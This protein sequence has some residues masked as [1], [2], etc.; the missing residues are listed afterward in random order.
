[1]QS[2]STGRASS[3]KTID[4]GDTESTALLWIKAAI[5][6]PLWAVPLVPFVGYFCRALG[7]LPNQLGLGVVLVLALI[8]FFEGVLRQKIRMDDQYLYYGFRTIR[9]DELVSVDVKYKKRSLIPDALVF[10]KFSGKTLSL[11]LDGL[12]ETNAEILLKHLQ[13]RNSNL[14]TTPVISTLLKC[15]RVV[16]KP[17]VDT[18]ERLIVP[19]HS[20]QLVDDSVDAF[21][22]TAMKWNR[23]GPL[24]VCTTLAPVWMMAVSTLYACLQASSFDQLQNLNLNAF[25]GRT[26]FGLQE[27]FLTSVEEGAK[28]AITNNA[29]PLLFYSTCAVLAAFIFY[30]Q[31]LCLRPN[32]VLADN[33]GIS[34]QLSSGSLNIPMGSVDWS[35]IQ[36]ASLYKP[37]GI[38]SWKIRL[39]KSDDSFFDISLSAILPEDRSRLLKR[40]EWLIPNCEI[41]AELSQSMLPKADKN[42]TEI[43]LQSL[44]QSPE[45]KT[46]EPLAPGQI[47]A[48]ERF[49]ILKTIGVGGQGTAYLCRNLLD[50]A[51]AVVVLKETILPVFVED[52]VRRKA[53]ERFEQEARMLKSIENDGIVK[54]IDFFIEDHRA[55]LVLEHI[56]GCT[57][58][59]LIARDGA[60]KEGQAHDLALQMCE[61]LKVLHSNSMVHRDFT[62]DNLILNSKG[63]LKLIDFNVAQQIQEGSTGTIVGKHAYVPPEQFRGKAT[64]QSDIY[65]F[66]ATLHYLLTGADPEPISQS[67]PVSKNPSVCDSLDSIVKRATALQLNKRYENAEDIEADLIAMN[68]HC[69]DDGPP[70]T[71]NVRSKEGMVELG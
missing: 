59:E 10:N 69:L 3:I 57:L 4:Y 56:D 39:K 17:P 8:Y 36:R 29:D 58:R 55:Y 5:L 28:A 61:L 27:S 67:S 7:G 25:V 1:M 44:I 52:G 68:E 34:L 48:E 23:M 19:Y 12:S 45:R 66:G 33:K 21:R 15:K 9:I 11:K 47:L 37:G 41:D 32:V 18:Q 51:S 38:D 43:W 42:Y 46:L 60:M 64:T 13:A 53:L 70:L 16:P 40:M 26:L 14:K 6:V 30:I 50:K 49:E 24:L 71:V 62:P 31:Y 63:R 20:R 35:E 65:A 2:V 22:L 54:L